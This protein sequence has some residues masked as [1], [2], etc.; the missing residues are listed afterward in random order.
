[1]MTVSERIANYKNTTAAQAYIIGI[2]FQGLVYEWI[3]NELPDFLFSDDHESGSHGRIEKLRFRP[4]VE[5]KWLIVHR[6]GAHAIGTPEEILA[7]RKN[8]GEAWEKYQTEKA[9]QVWHKDS[10]PYYKDGDL[11]KDGIKYQVKFENAS[12]ANENTILDGMKF[13]GLM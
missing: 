12:F 13:W 11:T 9:G 4:T 5:E 6:Y 10:I 8:K 7:G 2:I 1:M 3:I